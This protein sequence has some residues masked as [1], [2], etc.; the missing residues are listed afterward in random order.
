MQ[1]I[2]EQVL[3]NPEIGYGFTRLIPKAR[4]TYVSNC[5]HYI[6]SS[7]V[8]FIQKICSWFPFWENIVNL[9]NQTTVSA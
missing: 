4:F 6:S 3:H 1:N 9:T 2:I 7:H 8:S 5:K